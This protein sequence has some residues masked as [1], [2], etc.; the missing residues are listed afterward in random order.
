MN[1]KIVKSILLVF[2][3]TL[4]MLQLSTSAFAWNIAIVDNDDTQGHSN[5]SYNATGGY[6]VGWTRIYSNNHYH[7]NARI[8]PTG[9]HPN[10]GEWCWYQ[11]LFFTPFE[12]TSTV[13][14]NEFKVYLWDA[15]FTDPEACYEG[16]RY[17]QIRFY[18]VNQRYAYAGWNSLVVDSTPLGELLNETCCDGFMVSES[19]LSGYNVGADA[20]YVELSQ[21]YLIIDYRL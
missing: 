4:F 14:V 5:W 3:V 13:Y 19:G 17:A 6:D 21:Y 11:W 18:P 7:D 20:I 16:T 12:K 2:L 8:S 9:L 10:V 1:K 15:A